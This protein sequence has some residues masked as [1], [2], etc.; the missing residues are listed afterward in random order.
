LQRLAVLNPFASLTSPFII[1][2]P[3]DSGDR[4]HKQRAAN[5]AI[6]NKNTCMGLYS[7]KQMIKGGRSFQLWPALN[8]VKEAMKVWN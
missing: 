2:K 8:G 6:V 4:F 5:Y 1:N 3:A 7:S